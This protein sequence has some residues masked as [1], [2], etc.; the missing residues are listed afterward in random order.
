M[1][2]NVLP[3]FLLFFEWE[4]IIGVHKSILKGFVNL[5]ID[6]KELKA[7]NE[8]KSCMIFQFTIF[9]LLKVEWMNEWLVAFWC[10][11]AFIGFCLC[12]CLSLCLSVRLFV[13]FVWENEPKQILF[14]SFYIFFLLLLFVFIVWFMMAAS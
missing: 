4:F 14:I 8:Y 9:C 6:K 7:L 5:T 3:L 11:A 2:F 13:Y 12:V 1:R 10:D